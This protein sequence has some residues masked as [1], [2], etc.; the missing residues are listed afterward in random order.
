MVKVIQLFILVLLTSFVT[1]QDTQILPVLLR[2]S[3]T[4]QTKSDG[5][6]KLKNEF[7]NTEVS[8]ETPLLLELNSTVEV[9]DIIID[10]RNAKLTEPIEVYIEKLTQAEIA[11]INLPL[12]LIFTQ[13]SNYYRIG[14]PTAIKFSTHKSLD[15]RVPLES[16]IPTDKLQVLWYV[17]P[18]RGTHLLE[19]KWLGLS[20]EVDDELDKVIFRSGDLFP[21]GMVFVLAHASRNSSL[22]TQQVDDRI[23][24]THISVNLNKSSNVICSGVDFDGASLLEPNS[25]VEVNGVILDSRDANLT[26]PIE[27]FADILTDAEILNLVPISDGHALVSSYYRIRSPDVSYLVN[28]D[29]LYIGVPIENGISTEN[30]WRIAYS[31]VGQA[32]HITSP[33]WF[34]A[35]IEFDGL[36][37]KAIFSVPL[38]AVA[39]EGL[40][41]AIA[42]S[43]S[44][45][46]LKFR[47]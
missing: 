34:S 9:N 35:P 31:D 17:T 26:K 7:C 41:I 3:P 24:E 11:D 19:P 39:E 27:V 32:T 30:L 45:K 14:S 4:H 43:S 25:T 40:I 10:S 37:N 2:S 44:Y 38:A 22:S 36:S 15:V 16:G 46:S 20:I 28:K 29:T 47:Q 42:Q 1:G 12:P 8:N 18:D 13:V 23:Q 33:M 21:E 6:I 5:Y